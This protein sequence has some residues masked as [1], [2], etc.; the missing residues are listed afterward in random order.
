MKWY[1]LKNRVYPVWNKELIVKCAD[2][3]VLKTGIPAYDDDDY[4]PKAPYAVSYYDIDGF[5]KIG[6][7]ALTWSNVVAWCYIEDIHNELQKTK[8]TT[9]KEEKKTDCDYSAAHKHLNHL[10]NDI[11][12]LEDTVSSCE[13]RAVHHCIYAVRDEIKNLQFALNKYIE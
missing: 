8:T 12:L 10:L 13:D 1:Y 11:T 2:G 3:D 5:N 7:G 9:V 6:S 4:Y